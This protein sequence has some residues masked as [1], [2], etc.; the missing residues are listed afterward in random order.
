MESVVI[1]GLG[2]HKKMNVVLEWSKVPQDFFF[3]IKK[4]LI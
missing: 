2:T 4:I 3:L 1:L